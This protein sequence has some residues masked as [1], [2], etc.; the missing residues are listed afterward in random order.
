MSQENEND[1]FSVAKNPYCK[2][3]LVFF[4]E[5]NL[6]KPNL[7]PWRNSRGPSFTKDAENQPHRAHLG[8]H[9]GVHESQE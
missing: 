2:F 7:R 6:R 9:L 3:E 1:N 4:I 5:T 8:V